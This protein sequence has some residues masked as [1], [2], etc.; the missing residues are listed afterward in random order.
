MTTALTHQD[1]M[2][3]ILAMDAY[4]RGPNA[5]LTYGGATRLAE[6]IGSAKWNEVSDDLPNGQTAVASGFSASAY[7]FDGKTIIA[8]RGTD[9]GY[10]TPCPI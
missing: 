2:L 9:S 4:S 10:R 6:Q 5:Q 1:V 3:A 8:Y 7:T